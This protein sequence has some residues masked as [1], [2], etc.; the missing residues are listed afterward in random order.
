MKYAKSGRF[1]EIF[2][3][4][5]IRKRKST[6]YDLLPEAATQDLLPEAYLQ[7]DNLERQST[8]RFKTQ[9]PLFPTGHPV[10]I[11]FNL[12]EK[13]CGDYGRKIFAV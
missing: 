13:F 11:Y 1:S 8:G 6:A 4:R 2:I 10:A 9:R 5:I 7:A 3:F 12:M